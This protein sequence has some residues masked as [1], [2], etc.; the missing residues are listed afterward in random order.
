MILEVRSR[1]M[2]Q[3]SFPLQFLLAFCT[4]LF[5]P[6]LT[7]CGTNNQATRSNLITYHGNGYSIE[8]PKNWTPEGENMSDV[9]FAFIS[10][11]DQ[12]SPDKRQHERL[13]IHI[14][15]SNDSDFTAAYQELPFYYGSS[16]DCK[17]DTTVHKTITINGI[18]W[19]QLVA[20]CNGTGTAEMV[21]QQKIRVLVTTR[22]QIHKQFILAYVAAP[23]I[24]N[25]LEQEAF[26]PMVQSFAFH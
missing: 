7:G 23:N 14:Q 5:V 15:G 12:K 24:F 20:L 11:S 4:L 17:I 6:I 9:P 13:Y 18:V 2:F 1:N 21:L 3:W 10:F 25:Q 16:R 8:H 22:P 19:A 26:L